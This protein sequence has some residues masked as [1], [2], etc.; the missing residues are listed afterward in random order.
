MLMERQ[1][2][3]LLVEESLFKYLLVMIVVAASTSWP[4]HRCPP[5]QVCRIKLR[6]LGVIPEQEILYLEKG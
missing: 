2:S 6:E 5:L 1:N 3:E 4:P